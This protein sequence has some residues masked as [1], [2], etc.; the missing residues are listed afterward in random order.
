MKRM[1]IAQLKRAIPKKYHD[2]IDLESIYYD[3]DELV[4]ATQGNN[5]WYWQGQHIESFS[6]LKDFKSSI[7]T[8]LKICNC[9]LCEKDNI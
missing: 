1:S 5:C 3:D 4:V 6:T 7:K 9:E 2:K 8:E